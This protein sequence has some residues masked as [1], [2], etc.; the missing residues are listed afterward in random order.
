MKRVSTFVFGSVSVIALA[1]PG[2]AQPDAATADTGKPSE[3][4]LE[5]I[6]VTAQRREENIQR[7]AVSVQ[8]FSPEEINRS[9]LQN[10]EDLNRLATG[11]TISTGGVAPQV[12]VRG[13]GNYST[14]IYAEGAVASNV[15]GVYV[16]R[17]WSLLGGIFDLQR[18]EVLKGPQGTL[19]GRNA[20][21]GAINYLTIRPE[22]GVSS[23]YVEAEAGNF[24]LWSGKAAVNVPI[25]DKTALR[26][27]GQVVR[28]DGYLSDGYNDDHTDAAR[29]HLLTEP[30]DKLSILF[31]GNYQKI[32]SQGPGY[33]LIDRKV[34]ASAWEGASAASSNA[35]LAGQPNTGRFLMPVRDD[36][37]LDIETWA[38]SSEINWD[39]G[40][41]VLTIVPAY[42]E[43]TQD[44]RFYTAG[45]QINANEFSHQTSL[46]MRL[47]GDTD[48][49]KWVLGGF[50]FDED[51][52]NPTGTNLILNDGGIQVQRVPLLRTGTESAAAFGQAT[53]NVTD[54]FRLTG[55]LRYTYEKKRQ[56]GMN[57]IWLA[58][59]PVG[60][61]PGRTFD[62]SSPFPVAKCR[63]D[64][65]LDGE[66][67][68][69]SV[70]FKAGVEYDLADDSMIYADVST[71]FKSGGFFYSS[72]PG[73]TFKPEKLTAYQI[74]SKNR[75]L[76]NR[77]QLNLEAFY[78]N[79]KDH[80]ENHFGVATLPGGATYTTFI[81]ENAGKAKTYGLSVDMAARLT[82]DDTLKIGVQYNK[83]KYDSFS[84]THPQIPGVGSHHTTCKLTPIDATNDAVDCAGFQLV[85]APLWSGNVGLDHSFPLENG[86]EIVAGVM[87]QFS[88]F[89]WLS[90]DFVEEGRQPAYATFDAD[91][92]YT[93]PDEQFSISLWGK[94]LTNE[95]VFTQALRA[96]FVT[97]SGTPV[98]PAGATNAAAPTGGYI[99][100]S[101][102]PPRTYGLRVRYNF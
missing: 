20:S 100:G 67:T 57:N 81:T 83:S 96:P 70:T 30:T 19:Y 45:F 59:T 18:V 10:P 13:I 25:D 68:Y 46:E 34:P 58:P 48:S 4:M 42:R 99:G 26:V 16:S 52:G 53:F 77:L 55:G 51:Q 1:M 63:L 41:A 73:N 60:C 65:P 61:Q 91:L 47:G 74:G 24:D 50:Y 29:V 21:G 38:V 12:Y 93:A 2:F 28:R 7:I 37:H 89:Q 75:L 79:Y 39:L 85:R 71:G 62:T 98:P 32:D 86:G 72:S 87:M 69:N 23:G 84:F 22:L 9:G 27:A 94:N 3:M 43:A 44:A 49:F 64:V 14:N 17:Q 33:P 15:D 97:G 78:W 8:A 40:P 36:G 54:L 90:I 102:R 80:Q 5:E 66:L 95:S 76:D 6:V 88:S 92:T 101:I 82:E 31:T 11:V 56:D 35:V